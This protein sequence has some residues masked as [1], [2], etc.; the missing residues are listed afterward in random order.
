MM[1]RYSRRELGGLVVG[2]LTAGRALSQSKPNSK[3]GPVQVGVQSYSFRDRP[4]D[5]AIAG[6][7]EAG[8]NCC[9]LWQGHV[10][11]QKVSRAEL[12]QWRLT[13]PLD[14]FR[15][16][17]GKFDKAGVILY[18]YNLSFRD[19]FSDEEIAR[20]FE[21]AR[22]L[23]VV[24]MTASSNVKTSARVDPWAAKYKIRVGMHNHDSFRPNEFTKPE[25]FEEAM[26]GRSSYI[27]I[28]LDIGHFTAAGFDA[29]DYLS[30]HAEHI[31]TLHL[32]DR[33]RDRGPNVPW[34]QGDAPIK[35]VLRLLRDRKLSIPAN[36][37]YEYEG[38]D[39]VAE[40]RKCVAYSKAAL[41]G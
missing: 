22:A 14:H 21:M 26:R 16:V 34:G 11:P 18:A 5:A 15:E 28:N 6:M 29:V 30:K 19:D 10:E 38:Q 12:R 4:L 17:R 36:I 41:E 8:V 25:D 27:A 9:E 13:V 20:G 24:V 1:S 35:E 33:K 32:K 23:G 37:E 40:V 2:A 7:V 39:A 31:V 3:F